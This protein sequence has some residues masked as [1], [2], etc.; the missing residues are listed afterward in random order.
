MHPSHSQKLAEIAA[1]RGLKVTADS[2]PNALHHNMPAVEFAR[3][4]ISLATAV[5]RFS[6]CSQLWGGPPPTA[7]VLK[8][9]MPY[10]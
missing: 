10:L 5:C 8:S 9:L 4:V 7:L 3:R 2:F 6:E 1:K